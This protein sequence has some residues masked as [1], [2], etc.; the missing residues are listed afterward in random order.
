MS[1]IQSVTLLAAFA[2][3]TAQAVT[4]QQPPNRSS[5]L[6]DVTDAVAQGLL[7]A[8]VLD[9]ADLDRPLTLGELARLLL[10]A[11][12]SLGGYPEQPGAAGP[13]RVTAPQGRAGTSANVLYVPETVGAPDMAWEEPQAA[14]SPSRRSQIFDWVLGSASGE[15]A[16]RR[17]AYWRAMTSP[18]SAYYGSAGGSSSSSSSSSS[19]DCP[20]CQ[21]RRRLDDRIKDLEYDRDRLKQEVEQFQYQLHNR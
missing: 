9:G 7:P 18:R 11:R 10:Q 16:R 1:R 3:A 5:D 14:Y 19:C 15:N 17:E 12:P 20:H 21:E 13:V 4:A 6:Q 8:S 2:L